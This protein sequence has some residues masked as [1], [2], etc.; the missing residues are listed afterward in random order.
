MNFEIQ[1][2]NCEVS[3]RTSMKGKIGIVREILM[4][5]GFD[6]NLN[7]LWNASNLKETLI[8][9]LKANGKDRKSQRNGRRS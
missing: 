1:T 6:Q 5:T 9:L 3:G 7:C 8:I 2:L 4:K